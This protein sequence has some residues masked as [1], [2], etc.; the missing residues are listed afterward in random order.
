[1]VKILIVCNRFTSNQDVIHEKFGRQMQMALG[2]GKLNYKITLACIDYKKCEKIDKQF[3]NIHVVSFPL[4][5]RESLNFLIT[6]LKSV[7]KVDPDIIVGANIPLWGLLGL[8]IAKLFRKIFIYDVMDNFDKKENDLF[9][10]L[11][12]VIHKLNLHISQNIIVVSETL[13]KKYRYLNKNIL[14]YQNSVNTKVFKPL[15]KKSCKNKWGFKEDIKYIGY[16]GSIAKNRG[17][18]ELQKAFISLCAEDSKVRLVLAGGMND[19]VLIKNKNILYLKLL[20]YKK[21]PTL[22]N[23]LDMFIVPNPENEFTKYCFPYKILEA[24]ACNQ[25]VLT[26]RVGDLKLLNLDTK[27]YINDS[28]NSISIKK[29]IKAQLYSRNYSYKNYQRIISDF[30]L[31]NLVLKLDSYISNLCLKL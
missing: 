12:A 18:I 20:E 19:N 3:R 11:M 5:F 4:R 25:K 8:L 14:V 29:A 6:L 26:S 21:I 7:K 22:I 13:A 10:F 15:N 9:S 27:C 1:M 30:S 31:N 2:L 24:I 17:I 16:T 23:A 28:S